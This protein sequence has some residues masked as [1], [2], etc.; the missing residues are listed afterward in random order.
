MDK[1]L[2]LLPVYKDYIWGGERLKTEYGR[3]TE[4]TP[5]A[6]SW[7]LSAHENGESVIA[8][9][10]Y[11]GLTL[12][13]FASAHPD[14]VGGGYTPNGGF[15]VLIKL[16]DAARD[17]S[18]QVH[19]SDAL[20]ARENS[21]G[22]T[23]LW[24]ILDAAPGAYIF[25]GL[26]RDVTAG[27]L[28]DA[29]SAGKICGLLKKHEIKRAE[30]YLIKAGTLHAIGAGALILEIQESSDLTYRV[31]DYNRT[32]KYGKPRELHL[33]K[34]LEAA[35]LTAGGVA[36]IRAERRTNALVTVCA[37]EYFIVEELWLKGEY[38]LRA[39]DSFLYAFCAEGTP[40]AEGQTLKKG[41]GFF[42]PAGSEVRL[43]G[44]GH[45]IVAGAGKV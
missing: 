11:D 26:V 38:I 22:K 24:Y 40:D 27:E 44:E 36:P 28:Y 9:G 45:L 17:L 35:T 6:E 18:V 30:A 3:A 25:A 5:L 8:G 29:A 33:D 4:L 37:C 32:D 12:G 13:E 39:P 41:D 2:R 19:P 15:P 14:A 43:S 34:A 10:E 21:R 1:L 16:I 42:L 20:A 7:E 23:E 31:Y